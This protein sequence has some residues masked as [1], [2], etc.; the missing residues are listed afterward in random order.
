MIKKII[1]LPIFLILLTNCSS[2]DN[3]NNSI[4]ENEEPTE[5]KIRKLFQ[6]NEANNS[7]YIVYF[8]EDGT[9]LKELHTTFN[10]DESLSSYNLYEY[11]SQN[12]LKSIKLYSH[13]DEFIENYI[14]FT[15]DNQ[16]NILTMVRENGSGLG[17]LTTTFI[18][19]GNILNFTEE[20]TN[21]SGN[22]IFDSQGRIIETQHDKYGDGNLRHHYLSYENNE[23]KE[24]IDF[25]NYTYRYTKEQT[26][27]PLFRNFIDNPIQYMIESQYLYDIDFTIED[28]LLPFNVSNMTKTY[29]G[30]SQDSRTTTF[31]YNDLEMPISA[32]TIRY[33][34]ELITKTFEY[35]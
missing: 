1:L 24:I 2:D 11:D 8:N 21:K 34:N 3:S 19:E 5:I 26:V 20:V 14:D 32:N 4:D 13:T 31:I 10:G 22:I 29:N 12:N 35:Y 17:F 7:Q 9:I 25:S 16:G 27:N 23:L 33:G 6:R 15:Y 28:E 18:Y 30:S